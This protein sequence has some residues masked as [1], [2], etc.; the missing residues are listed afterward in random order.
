[1]YNL[2]RRKKELKKQKVEEPYGAISISRTIVLHAVTTSDIGVL[3]IHTLNW[4]FRDITL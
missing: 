1:M 2:Q 3:T 4:L